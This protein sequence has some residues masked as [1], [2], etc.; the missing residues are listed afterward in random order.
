MPGSRKINSVFFLTVL[1]QKL[2]IRINGTSNLMIQEKIDYYL[3]DLTGAKNRRFL[4][5]FVDFEIKKALRYKNNFSLLLFDIDNFKEINDIY[6]H[7]EGDRVLRDLATF[8]MSNLRES[9]T[10]IR[11]GGDEFIVYLPNTAF[12]NAKQV[13]EKILDGLKSRKIAGRNISIS[14]GIAEFPRDGKTWSELFSKADVALYRAKRRG[15]GTVAWVED[16]EAVP[17]IPTQQFID[18]IEE[19]RWIIESLNQDVKCFVICGTAGI[20][21][22]RLVRD[23]LLRVENVFFIQGVAHG[24]LTDVPFGPIKDAL[25]FINQN[26]KVEFKDV[27]ASLSSTEFKVFSKILPESKEVQDVVLEVD[28][29]KLYDTFLKVF[30]LLSSRKRTLLFIDDIQWAD[31][32]SL[33]LLYYLIKNAPENMKFYLTRRI[34]D[35]TKD[36]LEDFFRQLT[37][38]R[39]VNVLELKPF[40]YLAS[41]EF[42]SAILQEDVDESVIRFLHSKSGGNPFFIEELVKDLY[43]SGNLV[44]EN[45]TWI[46]KD[47][48]FIKVP[49][50]IQQIMR[51]RIQEFDGD[52]ILEVAA[53]IG[54]E[55]SPNVIKGVLGLDLGEIYD[56]IEKAIKRGILEESGADIFAF[57]EDIMRELILQDIS[58]SKRKYYHYRIAQW[59]EENK[60]QFTDPEE[61]IIRHAY[62]AAQYEKVVEYAPKVAR[63]AFKQFAYDEA[64]KFWNYYFEVESDVFKVT[65]VL[66]EY[67]ECLKIKGDLKEAEDFLLRFE[68]K[69][70]EFIDAEFYYVLSDIY[71]EQG[72]YEKALQII[73]RAISMV[74]LQEV[75]KLERELEERINRGENIGPIEIHLYKYYIQKGWYLIKLGKYEDARVILHQAELKSHFLTPYWK[76]TLFNVLGVLH[77]EISTWKEADS[78][79]EKAIEI[80]EEIGDLKGLGAS[81]IDRAILYHDEGRIDEA[82]K[83]YSEAE[84]AYNEIGYKSGLITLYIDLGVMHLG[85]RKYDSAMQY[86]ERAYKESNKI[87]SKDTMAL[88]LNNIGSTLRNTYRF[89]EAEVFY[90]RA[91]EIAEEIKSLNLQLLINRNLMLTNKGLRDYQKAVEYQN[92]CMNLIKGMEL[93]SQVVNFYLLSAD[94]FLDMWQLDKAKEYLDL[95]EK[96]VTQPRFQTSLNSYWVL[97]AAYY[98]RLGDRKEGNKYLKK[99][100]DGIL[101]RYRETKDDDYKLIYLE[102][103][104]YMFIYMGRKQA[105]YKILDRL[106]ELYKSKGYIEELQNLDY[107]K[108]EIEV[109]S[110]PPSS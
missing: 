44:F 96:Y 97:K 67:V 58:L 81:Y 106:T 76:G 51:M 1:T 78:Y 73:D 22:T 45:R 88:S 17:L 33:E 56:S 102:N 50:S 10:L 55:F 107:L 42:I 5:N 24:A 39:L 83:F 11:Y 16:I 62:L 52:K 65:K 109:L 110:M 104:R 64:K 28:R 34:G 105:A 98:Y 43:E 46:I 70:R 25:R 53:C 37:R 6:G 86:F 21:K 7:L 30:G 89:K 48:E 79:Y 14:I 18:R 74:N 13:A 49:Q 90:K 27:L 32:S 87:G 69:Y 99:Y 12:E 29:Y 38:E 82:L 31:K 100:H 47:E 26:N 75:E 71:A 4:S 93:D 68:E 61:L 84:K 95:V 92:I 85:L 35:T 3:D 19:R 57:K 2:K 77:A 41:S 66:P 54:H 94:L 60:G 91:L 20:G 59:I 15:K 8:V 103:L 80:R 63:K 23:T 40:D 36:Y 101:Q 72:L 108:E 9:D